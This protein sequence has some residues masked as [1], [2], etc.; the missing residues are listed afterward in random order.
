MSVCKKELKICL[1]TCTFNK[2]KK[3]KGGYTPILMYLYTYID[4]GRMVYM[5]KKKL[6]LSIDASLHKTIKHIAISEDTTV[7]TLVE[8]YI[9][10]IQKNKDVIKAIKSI[11]FKK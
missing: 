10:A 9:R 1:F 11:N 2:M 7:S 5:T 8:D 6:N 4:I 3:N